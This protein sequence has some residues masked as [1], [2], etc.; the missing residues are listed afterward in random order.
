MLKT[1]FRGG[2]FLTHF[3]THLLDF[4]Y[5][6]NAC[7][8]NCWVLSLLFFCCDVFYYMSTKT[9][10][11][12]NSVQRGI[13]CGYLAVKVGFTPRSIRH[14][15]LD[16]DLSSSG[17]VDSLQAG[18]PS[19]NKLDRYPSLRPYAGIMWKPCPFWAPDKPQTCSSEN[20]CDVS[21]TRSGAC[22]D[23]IIK[24]DQLPLVW[25]LNYFAWIASCHT[26]CNSTIT[27]SYNY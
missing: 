6:Q 7:F 2:H 24:G 22:G 3:G 17:A 20:S 25:V 27:T 15:L 23:S 19:N 21:L 13:W 14:G 12:C 1:R 4:S 26:N 18:L 10:K 11:S 5:D 8:T 16:G 9:P